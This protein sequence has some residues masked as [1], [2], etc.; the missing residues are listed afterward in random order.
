MKKQIERNIRELAQIGSIIPALDRETGEALGAVVI[1]AV[2]REEIKGRLEGSAFGWEAE[3]CFR[4]PQLTQRGGNLK[5]GL[6][7]PLPL[8]SEGALAAA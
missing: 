1:T 8:F 4:V 6:P 5:L 2:S 3:A 7:L